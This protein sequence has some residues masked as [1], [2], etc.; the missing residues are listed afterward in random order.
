MLYFLKED[1]DGLNQKIVEIC[2]LM[3][4]IGKEIGESCNE[5]TL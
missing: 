5:T 3:E 2:E 4:K 1:F